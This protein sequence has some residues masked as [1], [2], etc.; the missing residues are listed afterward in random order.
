MREELRRF[1][2]SGAEYQ[3]WGHVM[4]G[5]QHSELLDKE[6]DLTTLIVSVAFHICEENSDWPLRSG[7]AFHVRGL[8][9]VHPPQYEQS[10][11]AYKES[12][13]KAY[14]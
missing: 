6:K 3:L 9:A 14:D 5:R 12:S 8:E 4:Q 2:D 7:V 1:I 10:K 13:Y 11:R